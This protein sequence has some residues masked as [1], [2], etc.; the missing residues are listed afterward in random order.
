M[1]GICIN[2][3]WTSIKLLIYNYGNITT[4]A[5]FDKNQYDALK[6]CKFYND[7]LQNIYNKPPD[8][9]FYIIQY[10][11][12]GKVKYMYWCSYKDDQVGKYLALREGREKLLIH[13]DDLNNQLRTL[14]TS[15]S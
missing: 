5:S 12:K 4:I 2:H 1:K 10:K 15:Q 9:L 8:D 3:K 11:E 7:D 6:I 13:L 14:K